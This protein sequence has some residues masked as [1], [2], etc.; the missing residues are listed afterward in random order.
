[1]LASTGLSRGSI[2]GDSNRIFVYEVSGLAESDQTSDQAYAI[3][4][5]GT[6]CFQVPLSNMN[7]MMRRFNRLGG[8]II[9]IQPLEDFKAAHLESS[10][11]N[12]ESVDS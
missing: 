2:S 8:K 5:S 6:R 9:S 11:D 7:Q 10:V 1:M 4:E 12:E 3:R